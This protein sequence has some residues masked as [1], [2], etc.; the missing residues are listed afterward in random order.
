MCGQHNSNTNCTKISLFF[1]NYD[2]LRYV[3]L[4]SSSPLLWSLKMNTETRYAADYNLHIDDNPKCNWF[5]C[6][7]SLN[8]TPWTRVCVRVVGSNKL[9]DAFQFASIVVVLRMMNSDV[10]LLLLLSLDIECLLLCEMVHDDYVVITWQQ[11]TPNDDDDD[12]CCR[13]WCWR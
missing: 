4:S 10:V 5:R 6:S 8:L 9:I 12:D 3:S 2:F 11:L 7:I 1:Q 13:C